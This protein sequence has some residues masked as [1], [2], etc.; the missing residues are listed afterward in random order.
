[1]SVFGRIT[2][3]ARWIILV[4]DRVFARRMLRPREKH[5][6]CN[7]P[8]MAVYE[9]AGSDLETSRWIISSGVRTIRK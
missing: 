7:G 1:M 8:E 2:V 3:P 9:D 4:R 5:F 6:G